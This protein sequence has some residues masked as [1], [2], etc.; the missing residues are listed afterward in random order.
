MSIFSFPRINVKGL[1][2][3]N[4]GTANNDDYSNVVFPPGWGA[5]EGL[6]LRLA[7]SNNVQPLTYGMDD[8]T[9]I[10]WLQAPHP[11]QQPQPAAA[12]TKAGT[13]TPTAA[14]TQNLIPAEWN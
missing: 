9:F 2:A 5:Y 10:E 13:A 7:D 4:V 14:P 11:F 3:I 8:A 12:M 6:P 1:I